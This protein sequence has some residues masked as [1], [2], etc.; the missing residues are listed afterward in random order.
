MYKRKQSGHHVHILTGIHNAQR[1]T[2][3]PHQHSK[4]HVHHLV[5]LLV[6]SDSGQTLKASGSLEYMPGITEE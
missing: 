1:Q 4:H 2:T 6:Y 3:T 5:H